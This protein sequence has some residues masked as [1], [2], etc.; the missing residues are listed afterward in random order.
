[1][2]LSKIKKI[3]N[4]LRLIEEKIEEKKKNKKSFKNNNDEKYNDEKYNDEKYND[5][6]YNDNNKHSNE[7][8]VDALN[9]DK[10]AS[11]I[12]K[13][14]LYHTDTDKAI[15]P[16]NESLLME[17][18]DISLT[19]RTPTEK[20]K[21]KSYSP[22]KFAYIR[23]HSGIGSS[24]S[25]RL[26]SFSPSK[27]HGKSGSLF[28]HT[29]DK[30]MVLKTIRK[31][32]KKVFNEISD[33]Y[34]RH[35]REN[36]RSLLCRIVGLYKI[37]IEKNHDE[38]KDA[39]DCGDK[40]KKEVET[41]DNHTFKGNIKENAKD[42]IKDSIN[43]DIK[44]TFKDNIKENQDYKNIL[45]DISQSKFPRD[46]HSSCIICTYHLSHY[47][48]LL[49]L[50]RLHHMHVSPLLLLCAPVFVYA[51]LT[52]MYHLSCY[53]VLLFSCTPT[54]DCVPINVLARPSLKCRFVLECVN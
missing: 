54:S 22:F 48:V 26:S 27:M 49:L 17:N 51:C 30:S 20:I 25:T 35:M 16:S 34:F 45:R 38:V 33:D 1:M 42:S 13:H 15:P 37:S 36:K 6:K 10:T 8:Y 32:E 18:A 12:N 5:E 11:Y 28:Y 44:D 9:K 39:F 47:C 3:F 50:C 46:I 2:D 40:G 19:T 43:D 53:W 7:K 24:L 41:R 4:H 29:A 14:M 23:Q 52:C 31:R 21:I